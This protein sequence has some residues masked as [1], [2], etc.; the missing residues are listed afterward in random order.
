MRAIRK[1]LLVVLCALA[2]P[3]CGG[4]GGETSAQGDPEGEVALME[5]GNGARAGVPQSG[6]GELAVAGASISDDLSAPGDFDRKIVKTAELGIRA[7]HVRDAAASAQ[8]IAADFGGSVLSSQ[9]ESDGPVSA[10]LVLLVPS[11][12]FETALG[13]LRGLGKKV[14]TDTV[15]GE[16]VTE[17]FV[18]LESRERNLLAAEQSLLELYER[19][20]SVNAA[21]AIERELTIIRGEIEQVQGRMQYLEDR[22]ASSRISLSIEPLSRPAPPPPAWSPARVVAQSWEASLA[23]LQAL[24]TAVLSVLV[25]GWWLAPVLILGFVLWRR[26]TRRPAAT[27]SSEAG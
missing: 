25:F 5:E 18:D 6:G 20:E 15:S 1:G 13:E 22:T 7:E 3:A 4:G 12:E 2:L 10:D 23:V 26:H 27:G 11:A 9:I 17:E 19:A 24:A 8:R 16:D 14:T 21:L